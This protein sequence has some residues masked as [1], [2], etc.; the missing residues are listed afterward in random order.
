[1]KLA[2]S[3]FFC[4]RGVGCDLGF[5]R[6]LAGG[7]ECSAGPSEDDDAAAGPGTARPGAGFSG[8]CFSGSV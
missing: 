1:M 5:A 3:P 7:A 6:G 8:T 4:G 2:L